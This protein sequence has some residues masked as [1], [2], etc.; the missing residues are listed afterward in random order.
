M[1]SRFTPG[2]KS[3]DTHWVGDWVGHRVCLDA[4]VKR[5][6]TIIAAAEN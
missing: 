6:G 2:I 5:K 4:V 1:S 3:P